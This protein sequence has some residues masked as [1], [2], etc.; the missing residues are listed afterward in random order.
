[1]KASAVEWFVT[2]IDLHIL[3]TE[4]VKLAFKKAK[5]M[6]TKEKSKH[7][8]FLGKVSEVIGFEKT[9]ELLKQVNEEIN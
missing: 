8:L 7:Q 1:M 2:E 4:K 3:V 6:E 9:V 5:E